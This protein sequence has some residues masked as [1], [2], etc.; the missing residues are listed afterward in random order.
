[1]THGTVVTNM[2]PLP[3]PQDGLVMLTQRNA[4]WLTQEMDSVVNQ[5]VITSA[6]LDQTSPI[7]IDVI[8][9][10]VSANHVK[11]VIPDVAQIDQ[12]N[13]ATAN[14]HHQNQA[15]SS[16]A[17]KLTQKIHSAKNAQRI[18][19][20][21]AKNI[22]KHANNAM[23]NQNFSNVMKRHSHV[24]RL[25]IKVISKRLVTLNADTSP[26]KNSSVPGEVSWPRKVKPRI[27][28]WVKLI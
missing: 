27:S 25:K 9:P 10:S 11:K 26:H 15:L 13:V 12:F 6:K 1:M 28:I 18:K 5:L 16:N 2:I 3:A 17:T 8:P 22:P 21:V 4:L 14:Q 19:P 7:L 20:K 23:Q 24:S